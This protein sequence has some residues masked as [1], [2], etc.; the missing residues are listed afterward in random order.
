MKLELLRLQDFTSRGLNLLA[1]IIGDVEARVILSDRAVHPMTVALESRTIVL[2]PN[3]AG[4]YDL[5]LG[6]RLLGERRLREQGPEDPKRRDRWLSLKARRKLAPAAHE[7]LRKKFPCIARLNGRFLPDRPTEGLRLVNRTVEWEPLKPRKIETRM[8][9][10]FQGLHGDGSAAMEVIPELEI[11]GAEEDFAWLIAGLENGELPTSTLDGFPELPYA[12]IP[13]RLNS[14]E[15]FAQLEDW[16]AALENAENQELMR[17][18]MKCY[19]RKSEVRQERTLTGKRTHGGVRLDSDR[20]VEAVV[21]ARVGLQP[22]LFRSKG[23]LIEPVFDAREH[24]GVITFDM[25]DLRDLD[26]NGGRASVLRFLVILLKM[27]ENLGIETVVQ[28]TADTLVTKDD[29]Q[30]VCLHFHAMLKTA[31]QDFDDAFW[32]RMALLVRRG[33]AFPGTASYFHPLSA[34]DVA[35]AFDD[36][37]TEADHSYRSMVWWARRGMSSAFP[38]FCGP[39]FAERCADRVD[40]EIDTLQKGLTGTFDTMASFLP[41]ALRQFG[42]PGGYLQSCQY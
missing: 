41:E 1:M 28:A 21:G 31:E 15:H 4:L 18:L 20:L 16:E 26:W 29:G 36:V 10:F 23:S 22:A 38:E 13:L 34:I 30:A 27:Y 19:Q 37:A 5:A 9:P 3:V 7:E 11:T 24:L 40:H 2:D 32:A 39:A 17:S 25:N 12:T 6:A 14:G 33:I 42:R 8:P 35:K